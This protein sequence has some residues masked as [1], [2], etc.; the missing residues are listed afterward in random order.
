MSKCAAVNLRS[1]L[2]TPSLFAEA[3]FVNGQE[4]PASAA[5]TSHTVLHTCS[6]K[7]LGAIPNQTTAEV[8]AAIANAKGGFDEWRHTTPAKRGKV[9][10]RWAQLMTQ[11]EADCA[12]I[13]SAESGKPYAEAM[14]EHNYSKGYVE[15]FAGEAERVYGDIITLPRPG[16]RRRGPRQLL[17]QQFAALW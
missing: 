2:A 13:L 10:A 12:A 9:L 8:N 5:A 17:L 15:W 6:Q 11:H 7:P 3:A 4:V 14:G 16:V 1:V